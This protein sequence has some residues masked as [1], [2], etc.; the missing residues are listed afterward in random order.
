MAEHLLNAAQVSPALQKVGRKCMAHV[1][2]A[3]GG[4][5]AR[6]QEALLEHL[7][8]GVGRHLIAARRHEEMRAFLAAQQRRTAIHA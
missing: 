3:Q 4:I 6:K 5:Q 2:R 8:Q 1:V 7:A